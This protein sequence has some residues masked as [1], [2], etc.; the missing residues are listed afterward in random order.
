MTPSY[1][2]PVLLDYALVTTPI[3]GSPLAF[4]E[5]ALWIGLRIDFLTAYVSRIS[6]VLWQLIDIFS[7]FRQAVVGLGLTSP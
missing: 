6:K 2:I 3:H 4:R 7:S 5:K 1:Q